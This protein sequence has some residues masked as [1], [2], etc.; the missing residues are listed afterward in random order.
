[1]TL[2][3]NNKD[4]LIIIAATFILF[5][6]ICPNYCWAKDLCTKEYAT[7]GCLRENLDNL[8]ATDYSLFWNI[9]RSAGNI[10]FECRSTHDTASFLELV[11]LKSKNAEF[12][13]YISEILENL[14][15]NKPK[16]FFNSLSTLDHESIS[17]VIKI[18]QHPIFMSKKKIDNVF[19]KISTLKKY[20]TIM[21]IYLKLRKEQIIEKQ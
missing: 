11:N 1:M 17:N 10:A 19:S 20:K 14:I 2:S 9:L 3:R 21:D 12:N 4:P 16:C 6:T 8:Y 13:E 7:L 5:S 15:V 18:L